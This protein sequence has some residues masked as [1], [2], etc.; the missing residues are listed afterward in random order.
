[1]GK[2]SI[3]F[4]PFFTRNKLAH[5][6]HGFLLEKGFS[7]R[8]PATKWKHCNNNKNRELQHHEQK[9]IHS[10]PSQVHYRRRPQEE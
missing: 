3:T 1:M 7:I 6:P 2:I 8:I 5:T 9:S 10:T 4:A